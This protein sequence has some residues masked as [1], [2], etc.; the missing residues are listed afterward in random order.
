MV[1]RELVCTPLIAGVHRLGGSEHLC[2]LG[3]GLVSIFPQVPQNA[4]LIHSA[5]HVAPPYPLGSLFVLTM[6]HKSRR[7]Y[8]SN[9]K[10][11]YNY[12]TNLL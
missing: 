1:D 2:D 7:F 12:K 4:H 6:Y 9:T 11:Y 8:G 5:V 10:F 3:L